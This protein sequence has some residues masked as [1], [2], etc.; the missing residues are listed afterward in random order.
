M[1][2]NDRRNVLLKTRAAKSSP[3]VT[4]QEI[5]QVGQLLLNSH[6]GKSSEWNLQRLEKQE[7]A[8]PKWSAVPLSKRERPQSNWE[9]VKNEQ[10]AERRIK[11]DGRLAMR[12][13]N[14]MDSTRLVEDGETKSASTCAGKPASA[15]SPKSY[16]KIPANDRQ[17]SNIPVKDQQYSAIP[18]NLQQYPNAPAKQQ[19]SNSPPNLQH[20]NIP[21][22]QQYSNS[23]ASLQYPNAAAKQQYS[24]SP[25]NLQYPNI[26]AKQQ[27]ANAQY[28]SDQRLNT[29]LHMKPQPIHYGMEEIMKGHLLGDGEQLGLGFDMK[30]GRV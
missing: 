28:L 10:S 15:K 13:G 8:S 17:Y 4:E 2:L 22:K 11:S 1:K 23:P 9:L 24:S 5:S 25:A 14:R 30:A 7:H 27:F 26:P 16:L 12:S 20:Q 29:Q 21:A 6:I 19:Y 3:I 18:A